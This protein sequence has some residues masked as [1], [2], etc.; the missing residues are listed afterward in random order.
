MTQ[1]LSLAP[2]FAEAA[3]GADYVEA[4]RKRASPACSTG[5]DLD[6][7]GARALF[8]SIVEGDCPSR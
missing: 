8:A 4:A 1:I 7:A 2:R 6:R 5:D 3:P